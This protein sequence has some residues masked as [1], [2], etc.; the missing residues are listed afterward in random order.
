MLVPLSAVLAQPDGAVVQVVRDG[1]VDSRRVVTGL[2]NAT[3]VEVAQGLAE[4]E[5]IVSVSG[6]FVRAG[7]RV[8]AVQGS[9]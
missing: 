8:T 6:T 9:R 5:T 4:G 1:V 3:Q 7:D 2:R